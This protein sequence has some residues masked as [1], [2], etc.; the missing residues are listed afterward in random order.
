MS[1][2]IPCRIIII[3]GG[4]AIGNLTTAIGLVTGAEELSPDV[5][6]VA[7]EVTAALADLNEK[8]ERMLAVMADEVSQIPGG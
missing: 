8:V 1:L 7:A 5:T 6:D 4:R 2:C 3:D